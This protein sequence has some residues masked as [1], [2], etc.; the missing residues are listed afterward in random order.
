MAAPSSSGEGITHVTSLGF[1]G[2]SWSDGTYT[3]TIHTMS[4]DG[5]VLECSGTTKPDG[6]AGYE[7]GGVFVHTD[8]GSGTARYV[9]NGTRTVCSFVAIPTT[10]GTTATALTMA[11]E[12][13][14]TSCFPVFV[15]AATG[16]LGPKSNAG[17]TFNSSTGVLTATGFAGPLTGDVTGS[18]AGLTANTVK[19]TALPNTPT[20]LGAATIT[21]DLSNSN[22]AN[23]TNLVT[24]GSITG[25]S[26][27]TAGSTTTGSLISTPVDSDFAEGNVTL[28]VANKLVV[29][30]DGAGAGSAITGLTGGTAGQVVII[31]GICSTADVSLT[32]GANLQLA[33]GTGP[34]LSAN[35]TIMLACV[36]GT[37]WVE[38]CRSNN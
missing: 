19:P 22:G 12:A 38:V 26:L 13:S 16:D 32:D 15:T 10:A 36:D 33:G 2:K 28:A 20:D 3:V 30:V 14:D 23:V 27:V 37:K 5:Y 34:T 1:N 35:D 17:L 21:V 18:G 24:D 6:T 25:G 31:V 9:N 11:N 4:P 7:I 8:G 29:T